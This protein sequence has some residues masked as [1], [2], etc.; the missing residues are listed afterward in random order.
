MEMKLTFPENY[1]YKAV[2]CGLS[3]NVMRYHKSFIP[4]IQGVL[5]INPPHG[6]I[7]QS[8]HTHVN[9]ILNSSLEK[10]NVKSSTS[11]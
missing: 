8:F 11:F 1:F 4:L 6:F 3:V 7:K 2:M 5:T 9:T 10:I